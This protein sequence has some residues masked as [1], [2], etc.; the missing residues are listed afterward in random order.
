MAAETSSGVAANHEQVFPA[1]FIWGAATSAYQIEGAVS[2]DGRGTS[3]WDTFSHTPGRIADGQTGDVACD[4]YRRFEDDLEL[5]TQLGVG[6]YRFS[7][8]W[9]RIQPTGAGAINQA[10][11][12]HYRRVVARLRDRG[13]LPVVTLYHWDLPQALQDRGGWA[14]REIAQRFAD[15]AGIVARGLGDEVAMWITVNEP[16]VVANVGYRWGRHAPGISDP[17]QASAV[18]HHLLLGHGLAVDA[19]R[20]AAGP[21]AQVGITLNL[22][23]VRAAD[24]AS[25]EAA[26]IIDAE[27]NG[28]FLEPVLAGRYPGQLPAEV[29][30]SPE[31]IQDGDMIQISRPIDFLGVNYYRPTVVRHSTG[32]GLRAGE[33]ELPGHPG[34]VGVSPTHL[35]T[36]DMGWPVDPQGL[37]ELLRRLRQDYPQ[38]PLYI[39]ES[40]AAFADQ[41]GPDGVV[42]DPK[43]VDYLQGH[44][45][46]AWRAIRDGVDLRGYFVWSLLD[47][48]EWDQGYSQ[49]FGLFYVDYATQRRIPKRSSRWF[50]D[51]A[52]S[53][54]LP[55]VPHGAPG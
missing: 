11:L 19:L 32:D 30:P 35:P 50:Q 40:G 21:G 16:W 22:T 17:R 34:I 29:H 8:A 41:I 39:T 3:I 54:R 23:S 46:A 12:D 51:V 24:G 27:A 37:F 44:V 53:N 25:V 26:A 49:R 13:I 48:F 1:G 43:R 15:Y 33:T 18:T 31:L 5:L 9:P 42:D 45:A 10:G 38:I 4:S 36:T 14:S 2:A 20:A 28:L 47:N 55:A 6:A 52:T 7:I